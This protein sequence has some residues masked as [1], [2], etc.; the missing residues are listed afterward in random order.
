MALYPTI[1]S[2]N[3][4]QKGKTFT[5]LVVSDGIAPTEKFMYSSTE[6][7]KFTY[8]YGP[9][10]NQGVVIPKGK[11]VEPAGAEWDYETS[12]NV[13]AIKIATAGSTKA[14][15]VNLFN[16]YERK[17]DLYAGNQPTVITKQYIEVPYIQTADLTLSEAITKGIHYG[18]AYGATTNAIAAG[19]YVKVGSYGNFTKFDTLNDDPLAVVGQV[20]AVETDL[21][22]LGMLQ[23]FHDLEDNELKDLEKLLRDYPSPGRTSK[24]ND[25]AAVPGAYGKGALSEDLMNPDKYKLN[26]WA[27]IPFLTDGFFKARTD[28]AA[29]NATAKSG[30]AFVEADKVESVRLVG[31]ITTKADGSFQV[32][33]YRGSM[34]IIKLKDKM[35]QDATSTLTV[36]LS[37]GA[38]TPTLTDINANNMHVDYFNN[39]IVIYFSENIAADTYVSVAGTFLV[40]PVAGVP[41]D[42][43]FQAGMGA[44]RI[45]LK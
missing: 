33:D 35:V 28:I 41:T 45:L 2:Y 17:R 18:A 44:V 26:Y 16:I 1:G 4:T 8:E 19:D 10:G 11:V 5:S 37:D 31:N 38:A 20:W 15:G 39:S 36:K 40:N 14:F 13:P 43:D 7:V 3:L 30:A 34:V 27:G 42:W 12:S 32:T 6:A 25:P 22:P 9:A 21:P 24:G 29:F 23:Y